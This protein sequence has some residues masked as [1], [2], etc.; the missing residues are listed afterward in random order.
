MSL[1]KFR[2][3]FILIGLLIIL[4]IMIYM[5]ANPIVVHASSITDVMQDY[6]SNNIPDNE[7]M[8][9]G[10][11]FITK[12]FGMLIST[13]IIFLFLGVTL[14]TIVDLIYIGV[15]A[16]RPL[17]YDGGGTEGQVKGNQFHSFLHGS[18]AHWAN[19]AQQ[20]AARGD[21]TSYNRRM[22]YA[23]DAE[24]HAQYNEA[25]FSGI[26][27][28]KDGDTVPSSRCLISTELRNIV[29]KMG[30]GTNVEINHWGNVGINSGKLHQVQK[31]KTT[32]G[33]ILTEYL[34]ARVFSLIYLV[35]ALILLTSSLFTDCG[36]NVGNFI[37]K[38]LLRIRG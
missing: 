9:T 4:M 22:R 24:A 16:V 1:R 31:V 8:R 36:L 18:A 20:S 37:F 33:S 3:Q 7:L 13:V 35:V 6:S 38:Y 19:L 23:N 28:V 17:L 29:I 14:T 32:S 12:V 2:K 34:K 5:F 15:P 30:S 11:N 27:S 10:T 26:T 25:R 21:A